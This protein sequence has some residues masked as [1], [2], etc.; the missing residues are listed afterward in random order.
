MAGKFVNDQF[1]EEHFLTKFKRFLNI[2]VPLAAETTWV[3][4]GST[5]TEEIGYI[6]NLI[7]QSNS[8]H[9]AIAFSMAGE[10]FPSNITEK[11]G[12]SSPNYGFKS[13]LY[14][15]STFNFNLLSPK[16]SLLEIYVCNS[17][18]DNTQYI[19]TIVE[20]VDI[21]EKEDSSLLGL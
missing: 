17:D 6:R 21:I 16:G 14:G 12:E 2:S 9:T 7:V 4:L 15:N 5:P 10:E 18:P 11:I 19:S 13:C 3:K 1:I 8:P 20:I